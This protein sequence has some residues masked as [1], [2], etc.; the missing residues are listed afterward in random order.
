MP[1]KTQYAREVE[2]LSFNRLKE[3]LNDSKF[4]SLF[5]TGKNQEDLDFSNVEKTYGLEQTSILSEA[6][7]D[8]LA[9][10]EEKRKGKNPKS[11]KVMTVKNIEGI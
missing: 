10:L 2:Q 8:Q 9:Y 7:C 5:Q 1:E 3:K 4:L 11:T 6:M